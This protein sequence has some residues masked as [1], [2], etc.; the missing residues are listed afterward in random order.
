M[1]RKLQSV[2]DHEVADL[3]SASTVPADSSVIS[4]CWVYKVKPNGK[5]KAR[6]VVQGWGQ[7][8]GIDCGGTY[9]PV[10]RIGS[11]RLL[12]AV[13]ADR[14]WDVIQMDA[15]TAFLQSNVERKV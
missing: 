5:F 2:Q 4:T 6:S 1:R 15:I 8:H 12:L 11:Q 3:V 7:Q 13:A 10:C 14:N 9:A